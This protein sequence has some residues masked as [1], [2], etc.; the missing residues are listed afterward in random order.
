M[1]ELIEPV[2]GLESAI[3][4]PRPERRDSPAEVAQ[5][6]KAPSP[7]LLIRNEVDYSAWNW[8]A[9]AAGFQKFADPHMNVVVLSC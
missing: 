7:P 5:L 2:G 8:L 9:D 1:S 4:G 6:A 3:R